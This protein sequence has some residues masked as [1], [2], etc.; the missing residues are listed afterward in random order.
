MNLVI[1][2]ALFICGTQK[3]NENVRNLEKIC[4]QNMIP[5]RENKQQ[6]DMRIFKY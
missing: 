2:K 5:G 3:F 4:R 6:G 1:W